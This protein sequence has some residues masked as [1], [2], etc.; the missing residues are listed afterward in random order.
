MA[1]GGGVG[2]GVG[3]GASLLAGFHRPYSF[4]SPP[5]SPLHR[6]SP[7]DEATCSI[8]VTEV[9]GPSVTPECHEAKIGVLPPQ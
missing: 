7:Q 2:G 4:T 5:L 6:Y 3:G 8:K 9:A 1:G